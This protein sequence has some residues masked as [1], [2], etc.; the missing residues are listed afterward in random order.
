LSFLSDIRA[1]GDSLATFEWRMLAIALG[2]VLGNYAL[3]FLRWQYLLR[4]LEVEVPV[5]TSALV[6]LSGFIMSVTPGKMGEVFKSLLL[7]EYRGIGI[8]RTASIVVAER[9]L[10]LVALVL[11]VSL[12]STA[13]AHGRAVALAGGLL[14]LAI[15]IGC[16]VRPLGEWGLGV[17]AR[18]KFTARLSPKLREAYDAL[19]ALTRPAPFLVGG[20]YALVGWALECLATWYLVQGFQGAVMG[21]E[22]ATFGYAAGTLAGALAMLPGGLGVAEVGMTSLFQAASPTLSAAT[23]AAAT[24]LVRLS[25]LWFGVGLGAVALFVLR[26]THARHPASRPLASG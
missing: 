7:F 12:G 19:Q 14:V 17:L 4:R 8:A 22:G 1:L 5:G 18:I 13:F 16:T 11:L 25:T 26:A 15:V 24:I 9:L 10:D 23:A 20:V 21:W 3:R 2:L 6:F